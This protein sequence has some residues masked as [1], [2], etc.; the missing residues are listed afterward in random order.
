M[1]GTWCWSF[2]I[3]CLI[4]RPLY[5]ASFT[6]YPTPLS[7]SYILEFS[8]CWA[9]VSFWGFVLWYIYISLRGENLT[10]RFSISRPFVLMSS[11]AIF[12]WRDNDAI[13]A[14][15]YSLFYLLEFARREVCIPLFSTWA[16]I[17]AG[18]DTEGWPLP[19]NILYN[20]WMTLCTEKISDLS[21]VLFS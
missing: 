5:I 21:I 13:L 2:W 6:S 14:L 17:C 4:A 11:S 15:H 19:C 8:M 16:A 9:F 1:F 12:P 3:V 18:T 10:A 7:F 20:F